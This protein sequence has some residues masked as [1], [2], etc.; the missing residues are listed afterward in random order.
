[1]PF[2]PAPNIVKL[3]IRATKAGQKIENR[4]H[5]NCFHTPTMADFSAIHSIV[6]TSV[7]SA[8]LPQLPGDVTLV[9]NFFQSLQEENGIQLEAPYSAGT[10]GT[11][12]GQPGPNQNTICVSLRSGAAGRSARGR[13]Y[14]LGLSEEQYT[15]NL[16]DASDLTAIV[17][18]VDNL[19][20][21]LIA[22]G[23]HIMIV[24]Y[25]HNGVPRPGGP[26]YFDVLS[27]LAVDNVIDSQR[28]R[29]PGHGT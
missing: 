18:A 8:W 20:A 13:L 19:R 1:M 2:V 24:S 7:T 3:E 23:Y 25:I 26:V 12:A 27:V 4:L 17:G 21:Q 6:V 15:G 22:G 5:I 29:M 16:I 14:W 9:S 10:I 11:Q 28:R